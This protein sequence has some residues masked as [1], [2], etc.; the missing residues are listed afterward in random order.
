MAGLRENGVPRCTKVFC[1]RHRWR[2]AQSSGSNQ[3]HA[4]NRR[5]GTQVLCVRA[6]GNILGRVPL[7]PALPSPT[8]RFHRQPVLQQYRSGVQHGCGGVKCGTSRARG[9]ATLTHLVRVAMGGHKV[10]RRRGG[11]REVQKCRKPR[12]AGCL[13]AQ[14]ISG[15]LSLLC[16]TLQIDAHTSDYG[17]DA[18]QVPQLGMRRKQASQLWL[19]RGTR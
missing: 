4:H 17:A 12:T 15:P 5:V 19:C 1:T 3:P 2:R 16:D 11:T 6:R 7:P 8:D 13:W 9:D 14:Q 10:H 18:P